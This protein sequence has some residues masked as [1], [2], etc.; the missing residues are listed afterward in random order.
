MTLFR[1]LCLFSLIGLPSLNQAQSSYTASEQAT[2]LAN[3]S[4]IVD[5]HIDVPYRIYEEWV[6][7]GVATQ[8]GDFDTREP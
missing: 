2:Q 4:I 1:L 8:G 3:N 5:G 7:I 6:D